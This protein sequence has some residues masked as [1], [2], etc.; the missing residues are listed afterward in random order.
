MSHTVS[1]HICKHWTRK[2]HSKESWCKCSQKLSHEIYIAYLQS[3]P[4]PWRHISSLAQLITVSHMAHTL[5]STSWSNTIK[6]WLVNF[7]VN[8]SILY[9]GIRNLWASLEWKSLSLWEEW[10]ETQIR[11]DRANMNS[12]GD[13]NLKSEIQGCSFEFEFKFRHASKV[14]AMWYN[15]L[16]RQSRKK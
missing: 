3:S 15:T 2:S 10:C 7:N 8:S 16:Y 1:L 5:W 13:W 9:Q 14:L 6:D 4:V 12:D 11:N